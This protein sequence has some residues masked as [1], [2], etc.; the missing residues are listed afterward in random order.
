[1][2]LSQYQVV[3]SESL[4]QGKAW[5]FLV[6]QPTGVGCIIN[7]QVYVSVVR[8]AEKYNNVLLFVDDSYCYCY[9]YCYCR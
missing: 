9:C 3:Q 1:M 7:Q 4:A 8:H 2:V 6:H 5:K